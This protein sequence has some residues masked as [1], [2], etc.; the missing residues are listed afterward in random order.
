MFL[1]AAGIPQRIVRELAENS[2]SSE[3]TDA[4]QA[5]V[6]FSTKLTQS[7][8]DVTSRDVAHLRDALP[9]EE[10]FLEAV[11]VCAS[12]N[13]ANRCAD[14]LGATEEVPEPFRSANWSWWAAIG[15]ISLGMR[16]LMVF[17][18][19]PVANHSPE[20]VISDLNAA[21][22]QAGFHRSPPFVPALTARPDLLDLQTATLHAILNCTHLRRSTMNRIGYLISSINGD[23]IWQRDWRRLIERAGEC[24]APDEGNSSSTVGDD[25]VEADVLRFARDIALHAHLTTDAQV[26]GLRRSGM[27]DEELIDLVAFCA[28]I[29]AINRMNIALAC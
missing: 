16:R 17:D 23:T 1:Q 25:Q 11:C 19:R 9:T 15:A 5:L 20:A 24:A 29:S 26:E 21:L 2:K 18:N 3:L 22:R 27:S 28:G 4:Q 6:E 12:F 13:F 10:E 8:R 14:A 7:P